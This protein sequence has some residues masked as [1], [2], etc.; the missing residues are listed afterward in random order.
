MDRL[1]TARP[2]RRLARRIIAMGIDG[3]GPLDPAQTLADQSLAGTEG[4]PTAAA[5]SL[6]TSQQRLGFAGGFATGFG[7]VLTLPVAVPAAIAVG[8][9]VQA[10]LSAAIAALFGHDL[11]DPEV[12][13][14]VLRTLI[15]DP[16]YGASESELETEVADRSGLRALWQLPASLISS[17]GSFVKSKLIS[18]GIRSGMR[19]VAP[20]LM[21]AVGGAMAGRV[22][23]RDTREVGE[24]ALRWFS[25]ESAGF[26][27]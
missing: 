20:R 11:K 23:A 8:W 9:I 4:E 25:A 24:R 27:E 17:A 21:P 19:F 7:G 5:R 2:T 6:I 13:E 26:V 22:D 16:R 10:R 18:R 14:R 1:L 12:R 3:V 15:D